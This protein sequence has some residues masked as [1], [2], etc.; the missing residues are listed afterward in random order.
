MRTPWWTS[1]RSRRPRRMEIVSSTDRLVD[2][3]RLEAAL[4]RRV[5]LDVLAVLVQGRGADAVELA[6][7]EHAA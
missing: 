5:L 2:E 4:Q 7:G 6:A 1:Y 3:D